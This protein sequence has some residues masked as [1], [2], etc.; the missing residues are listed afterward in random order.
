MHEQ[1]PRPIKAFSIQIDGS[2]LSNIMV[3]L[4]ASCFIF[5]LHIIM[6]KE[7]DECSQVIDFE[8]TTIQVVL[9]LRLE[10]V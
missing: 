6:H 3:S 10:R 4:N 2:P 9:D 8:G 7:I 1:E 5:L